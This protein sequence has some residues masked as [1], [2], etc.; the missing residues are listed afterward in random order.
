MASFRY[1]P[2][3]VHI[4]TGGSEL[5][6]QVPP[7]KQI[8]LPHPVCDVDGITGGGGVQAAAL[9]PPVEA[10]WARRRQNTPITT[11]I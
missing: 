5:V 2:A 4:Q 3:P 10:A 8:R 1:Q 9:S 6:S 7:F 11:P